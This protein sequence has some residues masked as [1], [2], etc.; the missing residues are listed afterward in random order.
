MKQPALKNSEATKIIVGLG[1][2]RSGSA[3]LNTMLD[4]HPEINM[5]PIKEL[6]LFR[7]SSYN[8]DFPE[9]IQ[10]RLRIESRKLN[11]YTDPEGFI[12][13]K[14]RVEFLTKVSGNLG[15]FPNEGF[16]KFVLQLISEDSSVLGEVT[17]DYISLQ[18]EGLRL[19]A[20]E[21]EGMTGVVIMRDPVERLWSM[22][23]YIAKQKRKDESLLLKREFLESFLRSNSRL[24]IY[25]EILD[26]IKRSPFEG[27]NLIFGVYEELLEN[28]SAE[29]ATMFLNKIFESLNLKPIT[30]AYP[31]IHL[32]VKQPDSEP[33]SKLARDVFSPLW[34]DLDK[35]PDSTWSETFGER[36]EKWGGKD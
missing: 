18:D 7:G 4:S 10:E 2:Q 24:S 9:Y 6:R 8:P 20:Q 27:S 16:A 26:K 31:N 11:R 28:S 5:C 32:R 13:G 36:P 17:P 25:S 3:W 12:S 19:M 1:A 14:N 30:N 29:S 21:Y 33:L 15:N 23:K 35:V 34:I 22:A